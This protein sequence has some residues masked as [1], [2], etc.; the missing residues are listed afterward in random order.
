MKIRMLVHVHRGVRDEG[1]VSRIMHK[2]TR[3]QTSKDRRHKLVV[4]NKASSLVGEKARRKGV[5]SWYR[6]VLSTLSERCSI[7]S[8][9]L[10][11]VLTTA[12]LSLAGNM[13]LQE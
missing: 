9:S 13:A 7:M 1:R 8:I 3:R 2:I 6:S 12:E 4:R 5:L 10:I 11:Q